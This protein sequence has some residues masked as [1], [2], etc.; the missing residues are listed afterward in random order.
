[1]AK[2]VETEEKVYNDE[3]KKLDENILNCVYN[4]LGS[5]NCDE[6]IM[7]I[8]AGVGGQEAMLFVKDLLEMYTKHFDYLGFNYSIIEVE[9][10]LLGG[11][12]KVSIIVS[13]K[14]AMEILRHEAGVHRV[15]RIPT[16]EKTGRIHTS[17]VS[18]AI[19]PQPTDIE[20]SLDPKDLKIDTY[21]SSGA[22]GQNVN[23]VESAVRITH[24]PTGIVTDCQTDRSQIKNKAGAM[25]KLKNL[26]YHKQLESQQNRTGKMRKEQMGLG[27]R[28]E[29]IR[30][31]NFNQDRITDHRLENG[32]V[33]DLK[34][35]MEGGTKLRKFHEQLQEELKKL[36]F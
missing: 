20:V 19:L 12:K 4:N 14:K 16:T 2:L 27:L 8:N 11:I 17:A 9:K 7:E 23:K 15:Q 1:M 34:N 24:I 5:D 33:Y 18:V 35:F 26:I 13:A 36:S 25:A 30:T 29:K 6:I 22:G 32:T 10:A 31:Y 21:R 3:L 28:N